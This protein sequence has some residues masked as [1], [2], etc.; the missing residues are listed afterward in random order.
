MNKFDH[1]GIKKIRCPN[2]SKKT[3]SLAHGRLEMNLIKKILESKC[4]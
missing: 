4:Y 1:T 2:I 3:Q